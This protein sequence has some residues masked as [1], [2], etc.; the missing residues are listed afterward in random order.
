MFREARGAE[1]VY[2]VADYW[3][4]RVK[5]NPEEHK[6]HLL[7]KTVYVYECISDGLPTP[8]P[9]PHLFVPFSRHAA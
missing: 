6:Y 8:N 9:N 4:S 7:G 2:G 1:L 5:W 3:V